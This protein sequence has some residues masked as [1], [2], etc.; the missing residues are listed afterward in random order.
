MVKVRGFQGI[1]AKPEIAS[2]I[3]SRPYDVIS[4]EEAKQ[5]ANGKDVN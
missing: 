1:V 5:L 2:E 4:R 3:A